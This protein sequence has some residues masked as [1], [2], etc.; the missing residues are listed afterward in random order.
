MG[1]GGGEKKGKRCRGSFLHIDIQAVITV[2]DPVTT[3]SEGNGERQG[4]N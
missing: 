3:V 4:L 2:Y 1:P